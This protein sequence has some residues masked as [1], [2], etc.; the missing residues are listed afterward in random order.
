HIGDLLLMASATQARSRQGQED[1]RPWAGQQWGC[2]RIGRLLRPRVCS[3]KSRPDGLAGAFTIGSSLGRSYA[4]AEGTLA[5][6]RSWEQC[7]AFPWACMT[8]AP[9]SIWRLRGL[10]LNGHEK[11]VTEY[12]DTVNGRQSL[13]LDAKRVQFESGDD[14]RLAVDETSSEHLLLQ[15]AADLP[16]NIVGSSSRETIELLSPL[17]PPAL[18]GKRWFRER[19]LGAQPVRPA[20]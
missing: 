8:K 7:G 1:N 19:R 14:L 16:E 11:F 2:R 10:R 9:R 15:D 4:I 13:W 18:G 5:H 3:L 6:A 12:A 20:G 17:G